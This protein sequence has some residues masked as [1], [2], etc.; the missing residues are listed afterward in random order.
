MLAAAYCLDEGS[1]GRGSLSPVQDRKSVRVRQ[2]S[3]HRWPPHQPSL[4][5]FTLQQHPLHSVLLPLVDYLEI[6][7]GRVSTKAGECKTSRG[8][9]KENKKLEKFSLASAVNVLIQASESSITKV[10]FNN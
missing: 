3:E 9:R 4:G 2:T 5:S 7:W 1:P 6:I 10:E 8:Q